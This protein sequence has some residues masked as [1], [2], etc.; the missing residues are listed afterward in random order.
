M[1]CL[2]EE[3]GMKRNR[4]RA[5]FMAAWI[6]TGDVKLLIKTDLSAEGRKGSWSCCFLQPCETQR[7]PL[8]SYTPQASVIKAANTVHVTSCASSSAYQ[9]QLTLLCNTCF[10]F[11][12]WEEKKVMIHDFQLFSC[13]FFRSYS[14]T[15]E[16]YRAPAGVSALRLFPLNTDAPNQNKA[17]SRPR[18]PTVIDWECPNLGYKYPTLDLYLVCVPLWRESQFCQRRWLNC[19]IPVWLL[20]PLCIFH[21]WGELV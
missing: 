14:P 3:S 4:N 11:R 21:I 15:R 18:S 7:L 8:L 1:P 16:L 9:K 20:A 13:P 10:I 6:S 19:V 12:I 2:K 17:S 5:A